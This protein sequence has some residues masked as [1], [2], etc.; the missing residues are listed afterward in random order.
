MRLFLEARRDRQSHDASRPARLH[1]L[2]LHKTG[3]ANVVYSYLHKLFQIW[4]FK[5]PKLG[6][7]FIWD[8]TTREVFVHTGSVG[9]SAYRLQQRFS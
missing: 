8:G 5:S 6:C 7:V 9:S 2:M 3:A 4:T 1:V